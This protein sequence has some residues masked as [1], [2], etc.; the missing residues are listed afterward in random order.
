MRVSAS[1]FDWYCLIA[2]VVWLLSFLSCIMDGLLNLSNRPLDNLLSRSVAG[3]V[4][5]GP[6]GVDLVCN[7]DTYVVVSF[8][9]FLWFISKLDACICL[10]IALMVV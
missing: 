10:T 2:S 3:L 4:N 9:A 1:L 8:M 6:S 5:L 7:K